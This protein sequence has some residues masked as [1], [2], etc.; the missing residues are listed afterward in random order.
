LKHPLIF[1]F[2]EQLHEC[3]GPITSIV[4]EVARK[5]S[6]AI[7]L[8]SVGSVEICKLPR[9]TRVAKM[10]VGVVLAMQ[11]LHS[12]Q[13]IHCNLTADNI[14]LDWN[15]NVRIGVFGH[16]ISRNEMTVPTQD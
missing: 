1:N 9:E 12:Q 14:L 3:F 4:T 13:V 11:Y 8:P 16:S 2:C 7:H 6:L 15:W 10:I 5:G